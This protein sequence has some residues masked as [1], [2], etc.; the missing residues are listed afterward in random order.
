MHTNVAAR[1]GQ[2]ISPPVR[3]VE[4][5]PSH[6]HLE[7]GLAMFKGIYLHARDKGKERNSEE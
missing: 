3:D 1:Q 5:T 4:H 7:E 2:D 6:I